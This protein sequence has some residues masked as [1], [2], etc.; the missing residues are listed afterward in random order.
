MKRYLLYAAIL[1]VALAALGVSP[2]LALLIIVVV[3]VLKTI[4]DLA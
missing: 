4:S 3:F 2:I 1:G